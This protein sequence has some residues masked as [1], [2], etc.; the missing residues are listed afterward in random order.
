VAIVTSSLRVMT[1]EKTGNPGSLR[2]LAR[3]FSPAE[4][5]NGFSVENRKNLPQNDNESL[6][7][8]Y[9]HTRTTTSTTLLSLS[10]VLSSLL[11]IFRFSF[12]FFSFLFRIIVIHPAH[13]YTRTRESFVGSQSV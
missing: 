5:D 11:S 10:V 6:A 2:S 12:S 1:T 4:A 8:A 3:A 9:A 13:A 7:R